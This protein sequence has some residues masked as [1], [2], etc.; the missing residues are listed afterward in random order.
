MKRIVVVVVIVAALAALGA[1]GAGWVIG[2]KVEEGYRRTLAEA[3]AQLPGMRLENASYRRGVFSSRARTAIVVEDERVLLEHRISHPPRAGVRVETRLAPTGELEALAAQTGLLATFLEKPLV[4]EVDFSGRSRNRYT[5]EPFVHEFDGGEGGRYVLESDGLELVFDLAADLGSGQGRFEMPAL[6][7]SG[8]GVLLEVTGAGSRFSSCDD[9]GLAVGQSRSTLKSLRFEL[10]KSPRYAAIS[11]KG[12]D[13]ASR[14][15]TTDGFYGG[16]MRMSAERMRLG[17]QDYGPVEMEVT[18]ERLPAEPLRR[19]QR[20][21]DKLQ[22]GADGTPGEAQMQFFMTMSEIVPQLLGEQPRLVLKKLRLQGPRGELNGSG[23][24]TVTDGPVPVDLQQQL[25][26]LIGNVDVSMQRDLLHGLIVA[27][28][29]LQAERRPG[30]DAQLDGRIVEAA[31][32]TIEQ[33]KAQNIL[34]E[35]GELLRLNLRLEKLRMTLNGATVP[36]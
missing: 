16:L 1:V 8:D 13:M 2:A 29:Y 31:A 30:A 17:A 12:L 18:L 34:A 19:L 9:E 21:L 23:V 27:A 4:S 26:S 22:A 32:S 35:D 20:E 14:N 11:L 7:F 33:L 24:L 6:R 15:G 25:A 28:R 3:G 10:D 36:L 5:I